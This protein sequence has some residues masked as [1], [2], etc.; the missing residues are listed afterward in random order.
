MNIIVLTAEPPWP[1]DQG[2][3]L[4]NYY[5]LK[6]LA[7]EHEVTLICFCSPGEI[8]EPWQKELRPLCREI[9]TVPLDRRAMILNLAKRPFMPFTMAARTS[10]QMAKLVRN[11]TKERKYKIIIACQLKMASY[12]EYSASDKKVAELTDVLSVYRRRMVRFS[13]SLMDKFIFTIEIPRLVYWE[14]KIAS[15][16]DLSILVST[17]DATVLKK[18]APGARIVV[19]P[20]GVN[21]GYFTPLPH[22]D[23]PVLIFYGHLRY[24][25]NADAIVW[26]GREI[27]PRVKEAV[28]EV[29]LLIVGKEPPPLVTRMAATPGI[30]LIGYVP[31]LRPYLERAAIVIVP[32]RF[33]AGIRNKILEAMAAE[34]AVVTTSVGCEGLEVTP[35]THLEV[36]DEP[37][38]FA[39]TVVDLL[40]DH[41][42]RAL[43]ATN[44]RKLVESK[45]NWECIGQKLRHLLIKQLMSRNV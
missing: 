36:A 11:L 14:K 35:G 21:M 41:T 39:N 29:E 6:A 45:Y 32:L 16:V 30:S 34:R 18:M 38:I 17:H 15:N 9:Y 43:L 24:P 40:K 28:P 12:L 1:L 25:P 7:V 23:K 42:R 44:G 19:L 8:Y 31:D 13:N 3:K 37:S 4:R 20:N 26:F 5:L 2:D 10:S 27:F 33:G 22:S